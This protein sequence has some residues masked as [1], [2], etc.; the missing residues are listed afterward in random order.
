MI[1]QEGLHWSAVLSLV[2]SLCVALI[3]VFGYMGRLRL[4]TATVGVVFVVG[5]VIAVPVA[6]FALSQALQPGWRFGLFLAIPALL[7]AVILLAWLIF[8]VIGWWGISH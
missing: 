7:L 2:L 4:S 8:L 1:T 3:T 5:S 6:I